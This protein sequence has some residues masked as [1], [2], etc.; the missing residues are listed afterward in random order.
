MPVGN[1]NT[2]QE[3]V[4]K[5]LW[6]TLVD[7]DGDGAG[8]VDWGIP[9]SFVDA[10]GSDFHQIGDVLPDFNLGFNTIFRYKGLTASMLWNAQIGG[11]VYNFTKQWSY[12]DGRAED[13]DQGGKSDGMKKTTKYYEVLYNATQNNNHFVEDGT[14]LK[15]RE[16]S[17]GYTFNRRQLQPIFGD[18]LNQVSVS[19][20]GRNLLTF[21]DYTGFDPEVGDAV[22]SADGFVGGDAS[23]FRVDNFNAPLYRTFTGKIEIQF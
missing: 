15:L 20:I 19:F 5:Q 10:E 18:V 7:V 21:T 11:D 16:L 17:L 13:Q 3:G 6:G 23:L 4:S 1:G 22:A 14:Y 2:F 8:D 12:R 9:V